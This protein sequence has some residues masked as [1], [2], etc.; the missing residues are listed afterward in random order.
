MRVVAET[1]IQVCWLFGQGPLHCR[2]LLHPRGCITV[3]HPPRRMELRWQTWVRPPG[4]LDPLDDEVGSRVFGPFRGAES[5]QRET[6][7][8]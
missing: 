6:S 4:I 8:G 3:L 2:M 1:Q 5:V 7:C